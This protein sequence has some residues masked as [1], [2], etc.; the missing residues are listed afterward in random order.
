MLKRWA[1][2]TRFV[3]NPLIPLDNNAAERSLRGP[4]VER[5]NHYGSKSKRGTEVAAILYSLLET[6]KLCGI[7]PVLYLRTVVERALEEPGSVTLPE[8]LPLPSS[9]S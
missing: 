1:A 2:L 6:A 5:K 8:D 4:V 9:D 3:D 7:D